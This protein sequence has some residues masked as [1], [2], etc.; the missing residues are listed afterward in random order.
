M[1]T[2][3]QTQTTVLNALTSAFQ[4]PGQIAEATGLRPPTV[5]AALKVLERNGLLVEFIPA[6]KGASKG[7]ALPGDRTSKKVGKAP[8]L[9]DA[10]LVAKLAEIGAPNVK[11][12]VEA[13]RA[14]GLGS[15][16]NRVARAFAQV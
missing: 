10:A 16:R 14:M 12:A 13:L 2:L 8:R 7:Y 6:A 15:N 3:T 9:D 4:T 11:Q 5:G 1:S